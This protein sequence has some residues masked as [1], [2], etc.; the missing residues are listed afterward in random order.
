MQT[1]KMATN[2][3]VP[4]TEESVPLELRR[5]PVEHEDGLNA[6]E[7]QLAQPR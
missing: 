6:V 1:N 4:A 7:E 2:E 3:P 5:L